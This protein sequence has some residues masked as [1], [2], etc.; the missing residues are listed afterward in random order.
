MKC[1][2]FSLLRSLSLFFFFFFFLSLVPGFSLS[3]SEKARKM[4]WRLWWKKRKKKRE[5]TSLFYSVSGFR[6]FSHE[7]ANAEIRATQTE[8]ERE[9]EGRVANHSS[10]CGLVRETRAFCLRKER[11]KEREI[12]FLNSGKKKKKRK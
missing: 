8:R 1:A 5:E 7:R 4:E 9:R 6:L 11:E 3:L 2:L 12:E 10:F